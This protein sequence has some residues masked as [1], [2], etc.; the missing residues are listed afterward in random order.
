M[1]KRGF[2]VWFTGLSGAGKTTLANMLKQ[3]LQNLNLHAELLDGDEI[4]KTLSKDLSFSREDRIRHL[5]R[6]AFV[7][8][9]LNKNGATVLCSIISPY[10]KAR[11]YCRNQ[12][13]NYIEVYVKCPLEV[14]VQR[15]SKGLYQKAAAGTLKNFTGVSDPYEEPLQPEII[16][17]TNIKTPSE[18]IEEI[19][20]WLKNN[21]YISCATENCNKDD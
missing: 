15:D 16:L 3:E 9:L 6:V 7:V 19:V 17:E 18:C 21:A 10:R 1:R 14:L 4:R 20:L 12:V 13:T 2:T 8:E 5:E 11:E